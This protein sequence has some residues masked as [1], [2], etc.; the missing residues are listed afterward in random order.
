[1]QLNHFAHWNTEI[2]RYTYHWIAQHPLR[3]VTI[4]HSLSQLRIV[5]DANVRQIWSGH[6][7]SKYGPTQL[8]SNSYPSSNKRRTFF[9]LVLYPTLVYQPLLRKDQKPLSS[10]SR[11]LSSPIAPCN[12]REQKLLPSYFIT[13]F[14]LTLS[15]INLT[16]LKLSRIF[17]IT[18]WKRQTL[19]NYKIS[20]G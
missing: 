2:S 11:P 3:K 9:I 19:A 13:I 12:C 5:T 10:C 15:I 6:L 1:M 7:H 17:T 18:I 20:P 8:T 16:N 14:I 4:Y